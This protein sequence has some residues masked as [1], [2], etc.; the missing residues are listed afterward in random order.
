MLLVSDSDDKKTALVRYPV[1][2]ASGYVKI[3]YKIYPSYDKIKN[4]MVLYAP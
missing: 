2:Q 1:S 3:H 4:I